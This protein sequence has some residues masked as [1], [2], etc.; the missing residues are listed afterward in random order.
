MNMQKSLLKISSMLMEQPS[1]PAARDVRE[2]IK[3]SERPGG[4][5]SDKSQYPEIEG[6]EKYMKNKGITIEE[7]SHQKRPRGKRQENWYESGEPARKT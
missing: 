7:G 1:T 3:M 6:Y 5:A 2:S 4:L